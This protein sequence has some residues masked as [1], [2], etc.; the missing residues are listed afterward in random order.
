MSQAKR[1][2][3]RPELGAAAR[4]LNVRNKVKLP[5]MGRGL[6]T[7]VPRCIRWR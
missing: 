3:T 6:A 7:R 1:L 5:G 4:T 2:N